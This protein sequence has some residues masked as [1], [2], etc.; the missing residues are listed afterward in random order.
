MPFGRNVRKPVRH[1]KSLII[2]QA[3]TV[4]AAD[5]FVTDQAPIAPDLLTLARHIVDSKATDF[6]R[7]TFRDRYEEALL[8]H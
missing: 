6:D 3:S 8:A 4:R 7:L 2:N 5:D 1:R